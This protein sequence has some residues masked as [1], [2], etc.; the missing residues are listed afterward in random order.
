MIKMCIVGDI[1]GK[2]VIEK[3]VTESLVVNT[4]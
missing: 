3:R 2:H 1:Q 4:W